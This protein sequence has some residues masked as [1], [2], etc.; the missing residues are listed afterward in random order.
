MIGNR[1]APSA[2]PAQV[3]WKPRGEFEGPLDRW[4]RE[5]EKDL[6]RAEEPPKRPPCRC[7]GLDAKPLSKGASV[8][9]VSVNIMRPGDAKRTR[10]VFCWYCWIKRSG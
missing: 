7:C 1:K 2:L 4:M 6:E 10:K 9:F 8:G 3:L 5:A